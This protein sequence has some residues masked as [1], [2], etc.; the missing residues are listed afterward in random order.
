M[1]PSARP[2][3]ARLLDFVPAIKPRLYSIA[4][5]SE[6]HPDHI[7]TCIVEEDF[8]RGTTGEQRHGQSTWFLRNQVP[9]NQWGTVQ[10]LRDTPEEPFGTVLDNPP[11]VP[12]RV[13]PAVV[14]LP[15]HTKTPLVMVG[16]RAQHGMAWHGMAWHGI[17]QH[18]IA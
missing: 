11:V 14:H 1:F 15:E 5:A 7:H 4:S 9:G 17:A 2:D 12:C 8:M 18:S 3:I 16:L 13:S 6:M 10:Q